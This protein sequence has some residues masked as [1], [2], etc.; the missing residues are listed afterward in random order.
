L[1]GF[2]QAIVANSYKLQSM[3]NSRWSMV[4]GQ[5]SMDHGLDSNSDLP[6]H[7]GYGLWTID[8][9][10]FMSMDHGLDS[11][12]DLSKHPGNGL[13]TM[14]YLCRWTMPWIQIAIYLSILAMDYGLSTM[15]YLFRCTIAW[16]QMRFAYTS[17]LWT[18][19]YRP[20][21]IC[22][23]LSAM[24]Y[25]PWTSSYRY[26]A[27]PPISFRNS[28]TLYMQTKLSHKIRELLLL[29]TSVVMGILRRAGSAWRWACTKKDHLLGSL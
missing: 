12:S 8:H 25:W 20:W 5:W 21:T 28:I 2:R 3:D 10:L 6:K 1:F 7:P 11:N 15:D 19:D 26:F 17:R 29:K 27:K 24:D 13:W 22:R 18:M 14:D 23:G 4:D 9:G 16:I